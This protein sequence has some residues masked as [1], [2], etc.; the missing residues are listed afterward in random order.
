MSPELLPKILNSVGLF[1][2]IIGAF[3]VAW[4][5]VRKF[6]GEQYDV[7]PLK[8]NGII[9]PPNKTEKYEK[10]ESD[11]HVKM[12]IGLGFL[13]IGFLLQIGSNWTCILF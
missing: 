6:K 13:T 5:V 11:K 10:Y 4:E 7:L 9:P 2:D 3:L 8:M 12:W 1:F